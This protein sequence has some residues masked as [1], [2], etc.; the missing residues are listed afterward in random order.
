M[1]AEITTEV[2]DVDK[3]HLADPG[4]RAVIAESMTEAV[5]QGARG[6]IDDNL[7]FVAAW[8]FDL[9]DVHAEVRLWQGELDVLVPRSHG[10]YLAR[11]LPNATFELVPGYG[12][13]MHDHVPAA[14]AWLSGG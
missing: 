11:K 14:L 13:W 10:E 5:R 9:A 7:A 12:H 3:E 8:G 4:V 2:P 6:W 1:I